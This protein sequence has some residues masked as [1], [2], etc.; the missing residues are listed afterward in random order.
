[1]PLPFYM[2]RYQHHTDA[3]LKP[4]LAAGDELA[5]AE[6]HRRYSAELFR[7]ISSRVPG[8]E[9]AEDLL[10]NIFIAL[11]NKRTMPV[12]STLQSLLYGFARKAILMYVRTEK[13]RHKYAAEFG[14][15]MKG[16]Y[17]NSNEELQD[18]NDLRNTIE[19]S[20]SA[21]PE[22]CQEAFILSRYEHMTPPQIAERMNISVR[23]VENHITE[24]LRRLRGSLGEVMVLVWWL[25]E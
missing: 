2:N 16:R 8:R 7:F 3:D 15:L 18:E 20:I 9:A 17:D 21:L 4:L 6:L 14:V 10:Q 12:T 23:T 1:M 25:F 19:Q 22:R 24:A 5:L 11:W 13:S